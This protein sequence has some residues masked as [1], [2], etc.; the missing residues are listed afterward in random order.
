VFLTAKLNAT[1]KLKKVTIGSVTS[2]LIGLKRVMKRT[3]KRSVEAGGFAF[4]SIVVA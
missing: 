3:P 4:P 1:Y 2:I